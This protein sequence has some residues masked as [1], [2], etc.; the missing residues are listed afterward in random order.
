M[1]K[2]VAIPLGIIACII[3]VIGFAVM[4]S[5]PTLDPPHNTGDASVQIIAMV[6]LG[7]AGWLFTLIDKEK[8]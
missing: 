1:N 3:G 2:L 5:D 4:H 8:K 7:V 6:L